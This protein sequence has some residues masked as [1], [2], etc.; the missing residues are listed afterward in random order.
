M[1]GIGPL[2]DVEAVT[3]KV[4]FRG[5]VSNSSRH[6]AFKTGAEA[7][8]ARTFLTGFFLRTEIF[9]V[10]NPIGPWLPNCAG[11]KTIAASDTCQ[12][13]KQAGSVSAK[14]SGD[15]FSAALVVGG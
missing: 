10:R 2:A 12:P 14:K 6:L 4:R 5:S 1:S 15:L 13:P 9:G 8:G 11:E 3:T 7:L